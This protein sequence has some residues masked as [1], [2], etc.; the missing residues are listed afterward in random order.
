MGQ[1]VGARYPYLIPIAPGA[2]IPAM[3]VVA[4]LFALGF[5]TSCAE[6]KPWQRGPLSHHSMDPKN[7]E[8]GVCE[9][10]L[11]HTHDVR[12]G[13]SGCIG[14]AGGGCGCN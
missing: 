8:N 9:K 10:F 12:E 2:I 1:P 3:R 6:V 14:A 11:S 7:T 4:V 5:L 13:G